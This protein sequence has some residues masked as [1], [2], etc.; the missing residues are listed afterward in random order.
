MDVPHN[1]TKNIVFWEIFNDIPDAWL[2]CF[3]E[4]NI[5]LFSLIYLLP[6]ILCSHVKLLLTYFLLFVYDYRYVRFSA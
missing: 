4:K 5:L 3:Q 6:I 1:M 2:V